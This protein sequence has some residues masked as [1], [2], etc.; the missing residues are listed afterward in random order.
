MA[1]LSQAMVRKK[2][3]R[4]APYS[5]TAALRKKPQMKGVAYKVRTM[6]PKKPNSASRH[7]VKLKLSSGR[8]STC[9]VPGN[10]YFCSRYNRILMEGGRANDLPGVGYTAIRGV[11]DFSPLLFKKKRRSIY[12]VDRPANHT[13]HIKRKSRAI[14]QK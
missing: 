6:S 4:N 9:R 2:F 5:R 7:I 1:T 11:Y 13:T 10:K 12:G 3:Y 14:Y 8:R